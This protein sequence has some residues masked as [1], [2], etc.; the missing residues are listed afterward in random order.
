MSLYA[1][2]KWENL[3]APFFIYFGRVWFKGVIIGGKAKK[4]KS[5]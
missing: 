4:H 5:Q 1:R 3:C 2:Q